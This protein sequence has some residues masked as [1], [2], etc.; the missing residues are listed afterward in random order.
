MT[1]F[2]FTGPSKLTDTQERWCLQ[3]LESVNADALWRS[4]CAF[5][6]DTLVAYGQAPGR[7]HLFAP[8]GQWYN[9]DMVSEVTRRGAL[10]VRVPSGYRRRNEML[11]NGSDALHAFLKSPD[12]YRSGEWMTTNIA[13][14]TGVT[15]VEH[16]IP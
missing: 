16:I 3:E 1:I 13:R 10:L 11:V 4:G 12:F 9:R 14:R 8:A 7:V 5:G 6:L 2:S 15:V